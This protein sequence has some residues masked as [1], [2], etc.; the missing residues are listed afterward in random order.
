MLLQTLPAE[1]FKSSCT[2]ER[3]NPKPIS[4]WLCGFI[5]AITMCLVCRVKLIQNQI[6]LGNI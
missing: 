6:Y 1:V 3:E 5:S 4:L 2:D